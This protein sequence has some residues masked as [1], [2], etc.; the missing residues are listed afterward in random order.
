MTVHGHS[1]KK[2]GSQGQQKT[3]VLALKLA[4]YDILNAKLGVKPIL[5]L[6]D[7]FDRIDG[8]RVQAIMDKVSQGTYGQVFITDTS[9][10]RV[11]SMVDKLNIEVRIFDT[12]QQ[13]IKSEFPT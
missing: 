12:N 13:S 1:L 6:D 9:V 2:F 5:M 4:Q 8:N 3:F 10:D 11:P 7:L